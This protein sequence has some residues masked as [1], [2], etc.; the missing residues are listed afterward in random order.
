MVKCKEWPNHM[1]KNKP[2]WLLDLD[3]DFLMKKYHM[4][5]VVSLFLSPQFYD[6]YC[7]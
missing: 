3:L 6:Y 7:R 4:Y 1:G 2:M 5:V